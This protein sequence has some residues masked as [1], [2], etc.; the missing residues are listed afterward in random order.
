MRRFRY[1]RSLHESFLFRIPLRDHEYDS[2]AGRKISQIIPVVIE[3]AVDVD[4]SVDTQLGIRLQWMRFRL[5][6]PDAD[7]RLIP[8]LGSELGVDC[9]S[10]RWSLFA[11]S[12]RYFSTIG[13]LSPFDAL[14]C[15][16]MRRSFDTS[17]VRANRPT[18]LKTGS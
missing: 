12:H 6:I 16:R 2:I 7:R 3:D 9:D 5:A 15:S 14:L 4:P 10:F 13:L 1:Y 18:G 8:A 11:G 17:A